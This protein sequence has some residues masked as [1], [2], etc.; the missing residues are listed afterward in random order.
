MLIGG[1]LGMIANALSGV[2]QIVDIPASAIAVLIIPGG[3]T[4]LIWKLSLRLLPP[5]FFVYVWG[6]GF[7]GATIGIIVTATVVTTLLW[8]S[9]LYSLDYLL[10]FY[11]PYALMQTFPEGFITG[12]ILSLLVIYQPGWVATFRDEFYLHH[13]QPGDAHHR[14]K[15][16]TSNE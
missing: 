6:C 14:P 5:N 2:G 9:D 4:Y 13:K 1:V 8:L 12:T 11:F 15:K 3:T 16:E 7:F 10:D